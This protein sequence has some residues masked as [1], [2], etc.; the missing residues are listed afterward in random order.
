M[1]ISDAQGTLIRL[2][3]A[4]R[5]LLN[6]SDKDVV[7]KYNVFKDNIV[8]EQGFLPLIKRVFE[9]GERA[10]FEIRY[11]SSQLKH[12]QLRHFASVILDV[13][14]FPIRGAS[15]KI[16]NAVIQ[17]MN[18]TERKRAEETLRASEE[19]YRDLVENSQDLIYTHDLEGNLLSVNEAPVRL[20]GYSRESLQHM[21]LSDFLIPERRNQLK[22]YLKEIR[23]QGQAS[24]IMQ[25]Q[26]ATG[27][28]RYWEYNNA[29]RTEGVD[30]PIVRGM[31]HDV[32]EHRQAEKK[33]KESEERYRTAI[34]SSNDGVV[35]VEG[36]EL[37]FVNQRFCEIFGFE[38][39]EE[40]LGRSFAQSLHSDD[41]KRVAEYSQRRQRGETVP[42]RYE[43]KGI[44]TDGGLVHIE[45]SSARMPFK[46]K[47]L[48][49]AYLRDI[50]ERKKAQARLDQTL[51]N[52]RM[53]MS[54][55]IQ[56]I[57]QTVE[58][59]DPYTTGHQ[60]RVAELAQAIGQE[61]GL[62]A[63][64]VEGLRMAGVIH[65]LGKVSIPAEILSKPTQL[66]E[67]EFQLI[68]THPQVGYNILRDIEFPWPI[69]DTIF[70]HHERIDGSGYPRGLEGEAILQEAKILMVADVVEAMASYRPY[71]PALGIET[72]LEEIEKNA[73]VLYDRKVVEAC[74]RLFREKAFRFE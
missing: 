69:A 34:E 8:E 25:L 73:G 36:D 19:R 60:Q 44:R 26:T 12:L 49:L 1:W 37:R 56:V 54:G 50:S 10:R 39:P 20:L 68:R 63:D 71:R 22:A 64:R 5:D 14:V 24:G 43:F 17:H 42:A 62:D 70:Q 57:S 67:I 11:D 45:A 13:T 52:L 40:V 61:M 48:A 9:E 47:S 41:R 35:I 74:L 59:R 31:A 38:K 32:T 6:I 28:T 7:G 18:I 15:G 55:I 72:A 46:G 2:N 66:R 53:A 21:N 27:E 3:Q 4:C 23:S 29:L 33:L 30:I 51:E 65:D 16:T 58:A